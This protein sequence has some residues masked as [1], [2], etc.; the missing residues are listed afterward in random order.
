MSQQ[1]ID[2]GAVANDGTGEPLRTAFDAVNNNFTEIY[3]SGPVGSNVVIT[4]NTITVLGVNNNL[5]LAGNGIGNIQANSSIIPSVDAVYDV[6]ATGKRI[7]TVYAQYF[8]GNGQGLTGI[9]TAGTSLNWGTSNVKIV[10]SGGN[11]TVSVGGTSNVAVFSANGANI[12]GSV[13]ATGNLRTT[14]SLG[15]ITGANV[16]SGVTLSAF[17]NV[18]GQYFLGNGSQL[19]GIVNGP[20][21]SIVNGTSSV[22]IPGSNGN[23]NINV[24][25]ATPVQ[26][27]QAGSWFT[28]GV[29]PTANNSFGLGTDTQRWSSINLSNTGI[30][31]GQST[32]ATG[33]DD[34]LVLTNPVGG[35]FVISGTGITTSS[36][37]A[38]GSSRIS[39][40]LINGN[41]LISIG[42]T[43]NVVVVSTAGILV[44][45]DIIGANVLAED[46]LLGTNVSAT[47]QVVASGVIQS[48]TGFSTGGYLTVDG[49]T[50]LHKTTVTGN[51]SAT[52]NIVGNY[53]LG[54]GS[55]L[56]GLPATYTN[57]N[58]AAYLPV[59]TGNLRALT[60]NVTT[61][62][63]VS[64][65]YILGNGSQLTG[66]PATYTNANVAA[67]LPT[68]TG[69]LPSLSGNITTAGNI[70]GGNVK[71]LGSN[72]NISG[73][74]YISANYFVGNGSYLT[75]VFASNVKNGTSAIDII[76]PGGNINVGVNGITG[77]VIFQPTQTNFAGNIIPSTSNLYNLGSITNRWKNI[78]VSGNLTTT[79]IANVASLDVTGSVTV[80]GSI[81]VSSFLSVTGGVTGSNLQVTGSVRGSTVSA[82]GNIT[83]GNINVGSGSVTLGSIVHDNA[84]GVGNIGNASSYFNTLFAASTTAVHA[85]L[86]EWY[87]ADA[88]YAPGTVLSFGGDQEVTL[89]TGIND[90]RV[91]GVVSTTPAHVMNAGIDAKYATPMALSGRVPTLVV[92]T[93][94]KGDM[95]VSAGG[96]RAHACAEPRLGSVIGKALQDHAGG[97]GVI[98]IVVGRL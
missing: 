59:Y 43:A 84:N 29:I 63:N 45:G 64:G 55:Q 88:E 96:G 12:K 4:G 32:V 56:T 51:L 25:G 80:A 76:T 72:G 97:Q 10:S 53:I 35:Q 7:D 82:T 93:V 79:G 16:I 87:A 90:V 23:V 42:G 95:M 52:G 91:A 48:G 60:G 3:T 54:N 2:T 27:R 92:G 22:D 86:A 77:T 33:P 78:W 28:G 85:D 69:A 57:A 13:T 6:G 21:N 5:V 46:S 14:G 83:G 31:I 49:D 74:N 1:I 71:T 40:P 75:N 50:D 30:R 18:V 9:T 89:A 66:L 67:Y 70:T 98:E 8:V 65:S 19:T 68:Y 26:F 61:T 81:R 73:A 44:D 39:I 62:A 41:A 36:I 38:N 34:S 11:V 24:N 37:L 20:G 47:G 17:G 94:A 58:V 15:N